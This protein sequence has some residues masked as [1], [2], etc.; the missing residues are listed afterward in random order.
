[1]FLIHVLHTI[2]YYFIPSIMEEMKPAYSIAYG[3]GSP[4]IR[5]GKLEPVRLTLAQRMGNKKVTLVDNLD[6]YGIP[7]TDVAHSLQRVAAASATGEEMGRR[8]EVW[9]VGMERG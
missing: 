9:C 7:A 3:K 2:R 5:R 8:R 4:I 1:M 6:V